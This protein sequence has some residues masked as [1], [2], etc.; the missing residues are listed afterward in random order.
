MKQYVTD[1]IKN[2]FYAWGRKKVFIS[3]DTG[4]GKSTFIV[5][6]YIPYVLGADRNARVLVLMN[7]KLLRAQYFSDLVSSE[8]KTSD[9]F[10]R[11]DVRTYQELSVMS[12]ANAKTFYNFCA[13][14]SHLICD[15]FHYF[16]SDADFNGQGTYLLLKKLIEC[17]LVK[18]IVFMSAT[19]ET[20]MPFIAKMINREYQTQHRDFIIP[21]HVNFQNQKEVRDYYD[22]EAGGSKRWM[23]SYDECNQQLLYNGLKRSYEFFDPVCLPSYHDLAQIVA[24]SKG[25]SLVF[26]DSKEDASE[27]KEILIREF[28]LP[29]EE[30]ITFNAD[31]IDD[32]CNTEEVKM[33][34]FTHKIPGKVLITTSVLDNGVSIHDPEIENMA[35][36]TDFKWTFLQMIGRIRSESA[37]SIKLLFIKRSHKVFESRLRELEFRKKML[38][39]VACNNNTFD[40]A[41]M[42]LRC[43]D[44]RELHAFQSFLLVEN[45]QSSFFYSVNPIAEAKLDEMIRQETLF[46]NEALTNPLS[47]IIQQLDWISIS[48][49]KLTESTPYGEIIQNEIRKHLLTVQNYTSD[50]FKG[51]KG[52]FA[53]KYAKVLSSEPFSLAIR[54]DRPPEKEKINKL[55]D[56]LNLQFEVTKKGNCQYYSI[57]EKTDPAQL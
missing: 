23:R 35:I 51:F 15:E 57:T 48:G 44:F 21:P 5:R 8:I 41:R 33:L 56:M 10:S 9:L 19:S 54:H 42:I 27:L 37:S 24:T 39:S 20:T 3:A 6:D 22:Q 38:E 26:L 16:F 40:I 4:S 12:E 29:V 17:F 25:K 28:S 31:N 30:V 34:T 36:V 14:F 47:P 1:L 52:D 2:D 45:R 11:I 46:R 7:R 13:R 32:D 50:E 43:R 53:E 49:D 18:Q 55:C